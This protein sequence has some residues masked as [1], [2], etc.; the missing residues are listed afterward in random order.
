MVGSMSNV[1]DLPLVL[2]GPIVRQADDNAISVWVALRDARRV[3]LTIY[4]GDGR[5]IAT[6]T[7]TTMRL[8]DALHVVV[9]TVIADYEWGHTYEYDLAFDPTYSSN[10][11][12]S[13]SLFSPMIVA[14]TTADARD[15]L[16]YVAA[17]PQAPSRPS[18]QLPPA[19]VTQ[20]R[21]A[22]GSCRMPHGKSDDALARL[23][24]LLSACFSTARP[25]VQQLFLHGDQ[26]YADNVAAPLLA[27]LTALGTQLLGWRE[28]L[29]ELDATV[30]DYPPGARGELLHAAGVLE[31][32]GG[33]HLFGLGEF[34]AMYLC[35]FSDVCWRGLDIG[36]GSAADRLQ[37]FRDAL[38]RVRRALA[39]T[40]TYTI[41]DDHEVTD[42]WNLTQG[43]ALSVHDQPL[44]RRLLVNALASYAVFQAWG[45]TP[46]QFTATSAGARLLECLRDW[47]G[48]GDATM[49]EDLLAIPTS[50]A[51]CAQ[52]PPQLLHTAGAL[53]WNYQ[54]RTPSY[55]VVVLDQR[56]E[57]AYPGADVHDRP[58]L[59]SCD[60][61]T[62][63]IANARQSPPPPI[64]IVVSAAVVLPVP[65][66]WITKL[67]DWLR[68]PARALLQGL[69][70]HYVAYADD[71][72]DS[73][74]QQSPGYEALLRTLA[75][76]PT[77]TPSRVVLLAGDVHI[78][79]A[80]RLQYWGH[81]E[82][83]MVCAQ[84]TSSP[85]RRGS[86]TKR[87]Q[88]TLG[89]GIG[90]PPSQVWLGWNQHP[91][92]LSVTA[93][94][95][96]GPTLVELS[97]HDS[98]SSAQDP[99]WCYRVDYQRSSPVS[100]GGEPL[101]R[102]DLLANNHLAEIH[103]EWSDQRKVVVQTMWPASPAELRSQYNVSLDAHD[104]SYPR[105]LQLR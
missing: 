40:A 37:T 100:S 3:T 101:T 95:R 12:E 27:H 73:W 44:G 89:Y 41:F 91:K 54:L 26:I 85:L 14:E 2:A 43:W 33:N 36:D 60:A 20:V 21:L 78:G 74:S 11:S 90:A 15:A 50:A 38:P 86:I 46:K 55:E 64:T 68:L 58:A 67:Y 22:H 25:R 94:A 92:D 49:L 72:G 69:P 103:F 61:M 5:A 17:T 104:A 105:P 7:T 80:A 96:P 76:A 31:S 13:G 66:P 71:R 45:N 99:D 47:R 51:V 53:R 63:Q 8:G 56:T 81:G 70:K 32:A 79:Y 24:D 6:H 9:A 10:T 62:T 75:T 65:K 87:L 16:T 52:T 84:L 83:E 34:Y 98:V 48:S 18:V 77:E 88:Q 28:P 23:D 30:E 29:P 1:A 39:N 42:D 59:L 93:D 57:R 35:S 19:D 4:S 82:H 97:R 102:S